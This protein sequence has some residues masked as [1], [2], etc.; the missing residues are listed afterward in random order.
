MTANKIIKGASR[1]SLRP[2]A[3]RMDKALCSCDGR[4]IP[5]G[6]G[7]TVSEYSKFVRPRLFSLVAYSLAV[8]ELRPTAGLSR[9]ASSYFKP[10]V[11]LRPELVP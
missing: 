4:T 8:R 5:D 1:R 6:S 2:S 3:A 10:N 11:Q 7:R 9:L